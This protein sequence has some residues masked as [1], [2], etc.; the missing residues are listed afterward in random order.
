MSYKPSLIPP[1]IVLPGTKYSYGFKRSGRP[2]FLHP[3]DAARLRIPEPLVLADY[4]TE[5]RDLSLLLSAFEA[6]ESKAEAKDVGGLAVEELT[7]AVKEL[8]HS[9]T[10]QVGTDYYCTPHR[11]R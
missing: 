4:C 1:H 9:D 11:Q 2:R 6:M 5:R 7:K 3:E 10:P 8:R